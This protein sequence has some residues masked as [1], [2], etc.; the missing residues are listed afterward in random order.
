MTSPIRF[1]SETNTTVIDEN[2]STDEIISL[3]KDFEV[4]KTYKRICRRIRVCNKKEEMH[5]FLLFTEAVDQAMKA[6]TLLIR[7]KD[8]T[9]LPSFV[10]EYP[11][12]EGLDGAYFIVRTYTIRMI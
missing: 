1:G 9:T 12:N 7:D 10:L 2:D 8:P 5:E 4:K 6:G 3:V 11:R